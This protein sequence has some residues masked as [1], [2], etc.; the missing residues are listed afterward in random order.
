M[1]E[2]ASS[3]F[4]VLRTPLL[5]L[6]EFLR[7]THGA[8]AGPSAAREALRRWAERPEVKEALWLASPEL[9][10]SLAQWREGLDS[11]KARKLER[12]LYRYLARM[13]ARATPFGSFAAC[14]LGNIAEKTNLELAA[15]EQYRRST[16]LDMEYLVALA[17][18]VAADP[19][20]RRHLTV[21]PNGTL[22]LAAGAY[23]HLQGQSLVSGRSYQLVATEPTPFLEAILQRATEGATALSLA[24]A[25]VESD[26]DVSIDEAQLFVGKLI[27]SQVLVSALTPPITGEEPA[28]YMVREL[29]QAHVIELAASLNKIDEKLRVLDHAGLGA[30][31]RAYE[32]ISSAVAQLPGKFRPGRLIQV[33]TVKPV[34]TATLDRR[35]VE[36]VLQAAHILHAIHGQA[37][38]TAFHPFKQDFL[39][40]YQDREVPLLEALDDEAGIGFESSDNAGAEPLLEGIDFRVSAVPSSLSTEKRVGPL[41]L[42]KLQE[43]WA[44]KRTVLELG[45]QLLEELKGAKPLPLPESFAVMGSCF[46]AGEGQ[47]G[48]YLNSV[49]GVSGVNLA[50]RFCHVDDQLSAGVL[51]HVRREEA[52]CPDGALLAEIAHLP[53]GRVG[54]VVCRPVLRRYEIPFLATPGVPAEQQIPLSDLTVSVVDE[55]IVLRSQRLQREV[56][57]RLTT[58]HNF[59]ADRNLKLYKFLCLL[60][61]QNV[62]ADFAWDW[63]ALA[64]AA[65][66]PRVVL[67]NVVFSLARWRTSRQD[68]VE[69]GAGDAPDSFRRVQEWRKARQ[70]PRFV[71]IS[72]LD[73]QLLIDF[74]SLL[75]VEVFLEHIGKNPDTLLVEMFP[76]H[77]ELPARGPEGSF[78]HEIILPFV[79]QEAAPRQDA[80]AATATLNIAA[81]AG[82]PGR[83]FMPGSEWL[84]AKL[85]CSPSHADRLLLD[86]VQPLVKEVMGA[87]AADGWFFIRYSDPRWHLRLRLHGNPAALSLHVL[88]RLG[89]LA[90]EQQRQGT[91]WRMEIDSYEREVE[92]YG[93]P[94]GIAVAERLF[95]L[96]SELCLALL[97]LFAVEDGARLRWQLAF[98]GAD[99]LFS[100]LGFTL[101]QKKAET[102]RLARFREQ[103]YQ[104]DKLYKEQM[105]RKFRE[106]RQTLA[107][108]L[109]RAK[110]DGKNLL[111]AEA[112]AAF[113]RFSAG[114][115]PLL[116]QFQDLEHSGQLTKPLHE[117]AESF[118][119][120]HLNRVFRSS[121]LTQE[122]VVYEFLSRIYAAR[123]AQ[124]SAVQD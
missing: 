93:G 91:L 56:L 20:A 61:Y 107:A 112:V 90:A 47:Q 36:E 99:L 82:V 83:S 74:E 28:S 95:Q 76:V 86:L 98:C 63:G 35:L 77:G 89:W 85:Y 105:A 54:N 79:R 69:L 122:T 14:S 9:L 25:L 19:E 31:V 26:S 8:G 111:P 121:A 40:R 97:P 1:T 65:C 100:G 27:E 22:H 68:T 3:G 72:E 44:S 43:T 50:A 38:Q 60:Q 16:R 119:H 2:Y 45:D 103:E 10:Q 57:P 81:L 101:E 96:D 59:A 120:M 37:E 18:A 67:G 108:L 64:E 17:E 109:E 5:P 41:L 11:A 124:E 33:D 115:A 102:E 66:L 94:R 29:E 32:E 123:W 24:A 12:T 80:P 71:Y 46:Q 116:R 84:Y 55:R 73:N 88:P 21:R 42:R 13:T 87:G 52:A 53:E 34:L 6:E 104:V 7:L 4:F 110:V 78:V 70:I 30:D 39:E 15:R 48:F 49:M 58:A 118:V 117:F 75:A 92:R 106:E 23:H 114:L 62:T 51:E 113:A